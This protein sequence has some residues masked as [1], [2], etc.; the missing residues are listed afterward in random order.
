[1]TVDTRAGIAPATAEVISESVKAKPARVS[2]RERR[3]VAEQQ[4]RGILSATDLR[5]TRVKTGSKLVNGIL[6]F[7]LVLWGLG[8]LVWLA[9]ASI[10]PTQELLKHPLSVWPQGATLDN[11]H[12]AWYDLKLSL[13]FKNTLV[14]A[15]GSWFVQIFVAT[16]GGYALS[17]LK[18][19]YAGIVNAAIVSTL[20][21]PAIVLL[22]PLYLTILK[23]PVVHWRLVNSYWA[24]WLPAGATAFNVVI[25]KRF[26][27]NLPREIFEAARMDGAGPFRLFWSIVLPMSKPIVGVVSVFAFIAAWKDFLWP[28]LVIKS[29]ERQPLNVRLPAIEPATDHAVFLAALFISTLLPIVLFILFQR[30]FLKGTGLGG[31]LKG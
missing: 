1:M 14:M 13:Y 11:L 4:Q 8:P 17:V 30:F 25:V 27:D 7:V 26:F 5:S 23:V 12:Q 6:L 18:P 22:V 20:F 28:L 10:S 16:T 15:F 24:I 29:V 31:A 21:I 2:R 19:K 3:Q 9:K